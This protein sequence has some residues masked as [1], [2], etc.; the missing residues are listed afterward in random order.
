[1][2]RHAG[3][4]NGT[5]ATQRQARELRVRKPNFELNACHYA[6]LWHS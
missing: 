3:S 1:M 2:L 5:V 4:E 6:T